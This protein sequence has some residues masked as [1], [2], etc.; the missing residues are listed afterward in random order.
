MWREAS[1]ITSKMT[2]GGAGM[3]RSL[4]TTFPLHDQRPGL[5]CMMPPSAKMVVAVM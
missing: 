3:T 4:E 1:A 2:S 5:D